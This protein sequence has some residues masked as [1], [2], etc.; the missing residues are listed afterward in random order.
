MAGGAGT[1][2]GGTSEAGKGAST[3][4]TGAAG[5]AGSDSRCSDCEVRRSETV[6][7]HE[8]QPILWSCNSLAFAME[9]NASCT[10]QFTN[11]P[12]YCCASDFQPQCPPTQ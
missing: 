12:R 10:D 5:A 7:T 6:C 4:G 11:L 2:A 3:A 1:G 9:L 8:T